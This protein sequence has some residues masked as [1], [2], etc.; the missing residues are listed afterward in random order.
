MTEP[1]LWDR[2][3]VDIRVDRLVG[4]IPANEQLLRAWLDVGA[5]R[6]ARQLTGATAVPLERPRRPRRSPMTKLPCSPDWTPRRPTPSS[7]TATRPASP[8][9]RSRCLKAAIKELGNIL[10][11]ILGVKALRSKLAERVFVHPAWWR[12]G[13]RSNAASGRSR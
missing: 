10:K 7:S 1:T 4:G 3:D 2:Y 6:K 11:D 8:A 13:C 5:E 9:T 12:S